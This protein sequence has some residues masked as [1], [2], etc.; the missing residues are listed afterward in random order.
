LQSEFEVESEANRE[1]LGLLSLNDGLEVEA[2]DKSSG[3][4]AVVLVLQQSIDLTVLINL[5][6]A[7]GRVVELVGNSE[8]RLNLLGVPVVSEDGADSLG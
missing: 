3:H 4:S 7:T 2:S 8:S 5:E 6:L 1:R